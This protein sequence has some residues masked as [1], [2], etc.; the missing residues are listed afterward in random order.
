MKLTVNGGTVEV[1]EGSTVAAL[2]SHLRIDA[3]R[4]AVERNHDVIPRRTYAEA[5]LAEGDEVEIVTFVGG[6]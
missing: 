4:I 6:G 1:P 3:T 2:L 5:Q